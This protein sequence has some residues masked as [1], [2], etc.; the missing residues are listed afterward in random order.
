MASWKAAA[1]AELLL[2]VTSDARA[3]RASREFPATT[4][5]RLNETKTMMIRDDIIR[6]L[7]VTSFVILQGLLVG[8]EDPIYYVSCEALKSAI[9]AEHESCL[10]RL[11]QHFMLPVHR[12]M[13]VL[14]GSKAVLGY[15]LKLN[16]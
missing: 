2:S 8:Y 10:A 13:L 4:A 9:E 3:I 16:L 11:H 6:R 12:G 15:A 1:F 5:G 14:V 7:I